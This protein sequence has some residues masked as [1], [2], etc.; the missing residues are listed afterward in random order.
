MPLLFVSSLDSKMQDIKEVVNMAVTEA[1]HQELPKCVEEKLNANFFI[2]RAVQ[3]AIV[4]EILECFECI[5]CKETIQP[6]VLVSTCCESVIGCEGCI[7]TWMSN[8]SG[9]PKCRNEVDFITIKLKGFDILSK[10]NKGF[11]RLG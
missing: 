7:E 2:I 1:I 5:I 9:C 10:L 6:P 11:T 3:N 4:R 8:N